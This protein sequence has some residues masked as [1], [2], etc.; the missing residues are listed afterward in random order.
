MLQLSDESLSS[1]AAVQRAPSGYASSA[2]ILPP[3]PLL[4]TSSNL[5]KSAAAKPRWDL[6]YPD[7]PI[8]IKIVPQRYLAPNETSWKPRIGWLSVTNTAGQIVYDPFVTYPKEDGLKKY[9]HNKRYDVVKED[10]L[11]SNGARDGKEVERNL[12]KLLDGRTVVVHGGKDYSDSFYFYD[13]A[14]GD[15]LIWDTQTLYSDLQND[16]QPTL[17]TVARLVLERSI[18]QECDD[19]RRPDQDATIA[20][21][22]YLLRFPYDREA[23]RKEFEESG[24]DSAGTAQPSKASGKKR[25][26]RKAKSAA[27]LP[28]PRSESTPTIAKRPETS[29][30]FRR[31]SS[32]PL[33]KET[34]AAAQFALRLQRRHFADLGAHGLPG[35]GSQQDPT[36]SSPHHNGR[37]SIMA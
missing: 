5:S 10:L 1:D 8:S 27:N 26:L 25:K 29:N 4:S 33:E 18:R 35:R 16:G 15:S 9:F 36:S 28:V 32:D 17:S 31:T 14:L 2:S 21:E 12:M 24:T 11:F 37:L 23:K 19:T 22:L 13:D 30:S 20:M 3:V 6:L 7:E 34:N